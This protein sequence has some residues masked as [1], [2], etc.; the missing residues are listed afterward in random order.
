MSTSILA[1]DL[2][3]AVAQRLRPSGSSSSIVLDQAAEVLRLRVVRRDA[4]R[5]DGSGARP[6]RG[7]SCA[8]RRAP[9]G[10]RRRGRCSRTRARRPVLRQDDAEL[11]AVEPLAG[12]AACSAPRRCA[13]ARPRRAAARGRAGRARGA[14]RQRRP[15]QASGRLAASRRGRPQSTPAAGTPASEAAAPSPLPRRATY[16][17]YSRAAVDHVDGRDPH[18]VG[19]HVREA[20]SN[21]GSAPATRRRP[22]R[23]AA[24]RRARGARRPRRRGRRSPRAP[25][26]SGPLSVSSAD[27]VE[28]RRA[29]PRMHVG[30]V[31]DDDAGAAGALACGA[32]PR[33][34]SPVPRNQRTIAGS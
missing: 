18:D 11:A 22:R 31:P 33:R 29:A 15:R 9:R 8:R 17:V 30:D 25:A 16:M 13:A 32:A 4:P 24:G 27:Q 14:A 21:P 5:G 12:R 6:R 28:A 34:P 1:E 10:A 2:E 20:P 19:E 7:C 26:S 23:R 3:H